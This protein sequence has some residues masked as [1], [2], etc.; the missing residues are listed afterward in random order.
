[1]LVLDLEPQNWLGNLKNNVLNVFDIYIQVF[2]LDSYGIC[3]HSIVQWRNTVH[4][5]VYIF[6]SGDLT[7]IPKEQK[8]I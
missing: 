3:C 8:G 4:I 5:P 6:W 7:V 2:I 1:M